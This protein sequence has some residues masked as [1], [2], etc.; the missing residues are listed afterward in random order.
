MSP[1]I[2]KCRVRGGQTRCSSPGEEEGTR[3]AGYRSSRK[4]LIVPASHLGCPAQLCRLPIPRIP[5]GSFREEGIG[6]QLTPNPTWDP[7][8]PRFAPGFLTLLSTLCAQEQ[9]GADKPRGVTCKQD[10]IGGEGSGLGLLAGGAD[11]TFLLLSVSVRPPPPPP[12]VSTGWCYRNSYLLPQE[13]P[14][15]QK[16][17]P[18][19]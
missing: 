7:F 13:F 9:E 11:V 15:S 2:S 5:W 8:L 3:M 16:D 18:A 19:A 6:R 10:A 14:P 17:A 4:C 12:H 1:R